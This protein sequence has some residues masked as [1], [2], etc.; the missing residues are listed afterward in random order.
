LLPY[1]VSRATY[2]FDGLGYVEDVLEDIYVVEVENT[3]L[4]QLTRDRFMNSKPR[5]SPDGRLLCYLVS[6]PPDRP[7]TFL[8][9]LHVVTVDGGNSHTV[10]G[11]WG[12]IFDAEWC[13]GGDRLAFI[14]CPAAGGFFGTQKLDLWTVDVAGGEPDCRT[15][16]VRA[17]VGSRVQADL[18]VW[19]ELAAPRMC[20]RDDVAYTCG[21]IGGD[22][23]IYRVALTGRESVERV[24]ETDG[25]AYLVDHDAD[26]G[27][28]YL[29]TSFVEPPELMLGSD[30]ITELNRD[31]VRRIAPP[32]VQKLEVTAP[33]GLRTEAWALTP[34]GQDGPWP[35]VLYI[36]GGPYGA[37]GST[38][39]IDFQL[40]V[41][42]GFA[43]IVNNFRGSSGYGT[44]FLQ[45]IIGHWGVAG[46]L[47][48]HATVEEAVRLGIADP[49]RVGVCGY[50]HG[51][52]ATCWLVGTSDRFK[53]AVAENPSTSWTTAYGV[54]DSEWRIP[55]ELGGT[56]DEVP[57]VYR[58]RSPLTHATNCKTPL[59][60]IIGEADLRCHPIESEQYYRVLKS[61]GVPTEMLRLP[62]STHIGTWNGPVAARIA[63]NEALVDWFR[64]YLNPRETDA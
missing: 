64:R 46:A 63:Q 11:A 24:V 2:R 6:F 21:Q 61:N 25:S 30:L 13:T 8:P 43:V 28:L 59:L 12:G 5:W 36:H 55:F 32:Q 27:L 4:R 50:S 20:V 47:D 62:N 31:L 18:P 39:M 9:E 14:G 52:F 41:G 3:C 16:N 17:G 58:E 38:Y 33:D 49:E 57:D 56:P 35:T 34:S 1:R 53:A 23:V 19:E 26:S 37:F 40:L 15:Q 10:V 45:K 22:V 44:D 60:F 51:G 48:H 42:A 54:T 7:W 29:V